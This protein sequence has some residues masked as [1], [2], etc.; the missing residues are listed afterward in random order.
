MAGEGLGKL[1]VTVERTSSQGS[2]RA[3]EDKQRKCQT[4]IKPSDL[5]RLTHY[6]ENNM[7]ETDPMTQSS[8]THQVPPKIRGDYRITIQAEIWVGT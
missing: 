2:R 7:G 8:P 4:L 1:T 3:N 6:Q 5:M